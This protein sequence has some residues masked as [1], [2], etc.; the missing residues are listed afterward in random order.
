[1][2]TYVLLILLAL[3]LLLAVGYVLYILGQIVVA[4]LSESFG[5]KKPGRE[6]QHLALGTIVHEDG[7]WNGSAHRKGRDIPFLVAGT[8]TEPDP[9]LLD[10]LQ[11]ILGRFTDVEQR[12]LSFLRSQESETRN[13]ALDFYMLDVADKNYPD[14]FTLEFVGEADGDR[15]W[16][17]EFEA[18]QPK[19]TGFDD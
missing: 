7:L 10:R 11:S 6:F 16:R 12:A 2:V 9:R 19:S 17:V 8:D 13:M 14:D 3:L 15:V 1:M 5:K 18:G 4:I